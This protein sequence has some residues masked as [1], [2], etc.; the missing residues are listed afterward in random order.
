MKNKING[1]YLLI[2]L[3]TL[4]SCFAANEISQA[5][6]KN[7][8][9]NAEAITK[10]SNI[11]SLDLDNLAVQTIEDR[12]SGIYDLFY[13]QD[14]IYRK[15]EAAIFKE[16]DEYVLEVFANDDPDKYVLDYLSFLGLVE[17][18]AWGQ[19]FT[20]E[21]NNDEI[22]KEVIIFEDYEHHILKKLLP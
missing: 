18:P 13:F 21:M 7:R 20:A 12:L 2:F 17:H 19:G 11:P 15:E 9:K 4:L 14:G 16:N 6:H 3:I 8:P 1:A 22:Y 5:I 10:T